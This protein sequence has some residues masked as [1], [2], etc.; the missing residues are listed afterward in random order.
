[1]CRLFFFF[2]LQKKLA[3]LAQRCLILSLQIVPTFC[4]LI[5][6]IL[7]FCI[8]LFGRNIAVVYSLKVVLFLLVDIHELG[9]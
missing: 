8:L 7:T 3:S 4:V 6:K 2:L 5:F 9:E 1:M